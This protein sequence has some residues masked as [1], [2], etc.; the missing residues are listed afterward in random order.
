MSRKARQEGVKGLAEFF[1]H[2][3]P[4]DISGSKGRRRGRS[5]GSWRI[6]G[7]IE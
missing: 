7:A 6:K 4:D 5:G 3:L 1:A 2:Q